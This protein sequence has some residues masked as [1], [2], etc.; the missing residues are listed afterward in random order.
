MCIYIY[1]HGKPLGSR[2]FAGLFWQ[3]SQLPRVERSVLR[4][5]SFVKNARCGIQMDPED[6]RWIQSSFVG[7]KRKGS[8]SNMSVRFLGSICICLHSM[9]IYIHIVSIEYNIW[10]LVARLFHGLIWE[11]FLLPLGCQR[12]AWSSRS[13]GE[14]RSCAMFWYMISTFPEDG[15]V[16]KILWNSTQS[17][18][19]WNICPLV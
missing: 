19:N 17:G 5:F 16:S 13:V 14:S 10:L 12:K 2:L 11:W 18:N 1:I 4:R 15:R 9:C 6:S 7:S 3:C 8:F